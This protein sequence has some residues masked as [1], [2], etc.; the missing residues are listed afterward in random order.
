M[1]IQFQ[2][3][4]ADV[5]RTK[6]FPTIS[7]L[8]RA[9]GLDRSTVSAWWHRTPERFAAPTLYRLCGTLDAQPSDLIG[10]TDAS[11]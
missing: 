6:G 10:M 3:R 9:T 11:D 4:V 1:A 7:A 2:S 8:A 5:A